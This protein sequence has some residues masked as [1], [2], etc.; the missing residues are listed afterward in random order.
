MFRRWTADFEQHDGTTDTEGI[1]TYDTAGDWDTVLSGWPC[2]LLSTQGGETLRG[3]QVTSETTDVLI[4]DYGGAESLTTDM[5]CVVNGKT[6]EIV[7]VRDIIGTRHE[8]RIEL[9]RE[10]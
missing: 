1:P 3:S 4:G 10:T 2:Q 8:M 5:R 6:Y 7:S 9:K